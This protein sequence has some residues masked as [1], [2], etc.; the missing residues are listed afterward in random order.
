MYLTKD[1][2]EATVAKIRAAI[3][4]RGG[5]FWGTKL[6]IQRHMM[7]ASLF[8]TLFLHPNIR[9]SKL[10]RAMIDI[11]RNPGGT[12]IIGEGWHS[13]TTHVAR[14]PTGSVLCAVDAPEYGGD[15]LFSSQYAAYDALSPGC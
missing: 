7:S 13:D 3:L 2:A 8:R 6:D 15:T 11:L 5:I 14:P 1:L 12:K 10:D 9:G 4:A